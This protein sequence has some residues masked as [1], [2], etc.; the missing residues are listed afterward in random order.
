MFTLTDTEELQIITRSICYPLSGLGTLWEEDERA[1]PGESMQDFLRRKRKFAD[2]MLLAWANIEQNFT[3][4]VASEFG[5]DHADDKAKF[6]ENELT[7][8]QKKL[9]LK[10]QGIW[11]D[12]VLTKEERRAI[13]NFQEFRNDIFHDLTSSQFELGS[14]QR[15]HIMDQALAAMEAS[16]KMKMKALERNYAKYDKEH[17]LSQDSKDNK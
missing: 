7:L 8:E 5:L 3:T 13:E 6:L 11:G 4:A 1:E 12:E 2:L 17:F 9:F 15:E 10:Q 16:D 14:M